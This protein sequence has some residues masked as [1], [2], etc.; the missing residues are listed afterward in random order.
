MARIELNLAMATIPGTGLGLRIGPTLR[1]IQ[2][3][4]LAGPLLPGKEGSLA[5]VVGKTIVGVTTSV[6]GGG[7]F[8]DG[9][10][11]AAFGYLFNQCAHG[12]GRRLA[13]GVFANFSNWLKGGIE[14]LTA[15]GK[16]VVDQIKDGAQVDLSNVSG[17]VAAGIG[18]SQTTAATLDTKGNVCMVST[19]C[20]MIGPIVGGAVGWGTGIQT[21]TLT[22][23]DTR[24]QLGLTGTFTPLFGGMV[25]PSIANNGALSFGRSW[26][27][28]AMFG[29]AFTVCRQSTAP[30]C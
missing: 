24:Y 4:E 8:K 28:G 7:K 1:T 23:G 25:D 16:S 18:V 27:V 9:A 15:F 14:P 5:H 20:G 17:S 10:M 22:P 6:F 13:E 26:T 30:D 3:S 19:T 29:G 11:T 12:G 2:F 21:G